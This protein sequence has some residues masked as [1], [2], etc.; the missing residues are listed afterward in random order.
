M[1]LA[2][3]FRGDRTRPGSRR[4]SGHHEILSENSYSM[5]HERLLSTRASRYLEKNHILRT[6][7]QGE[8]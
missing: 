8:L 4:Q 2:N 6:L 5:L 3:I 1:D 7:N